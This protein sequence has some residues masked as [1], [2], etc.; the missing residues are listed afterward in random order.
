MKEKYADQD[1]EERKI[2]MALL[3]SAGNTNKKDTTESHNVDA[4]PTIVNKSDD[5]A[6]KICYKCKKPS[7]LSRD[8]QEHLGDVSQSLV[9]KV[10]VPH[11]ALDENASEMDKVVMEEDDI[12]ETGEEEKEKL[13]DVDYLTGN[14]LPTD[15]LLYTVPVCLLNH[16][17]HIYQTLFHISFHW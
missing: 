4:A 17:I 16:S 2:R 15:I 1:E 3:A 5:D 11:V 13:N 7:H 9:S 8:C 12:H 10:E 14:P 6:L